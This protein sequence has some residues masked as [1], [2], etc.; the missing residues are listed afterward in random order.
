MRKKVKIKLYIE[1][2]PINSVT[3]FIGKGIYWFFVCF[4]SVA[5]YVCKHRQIYSCLL[6]SNV[7]GSILPTALHV[8][9]LFILLTICLGD[10]STLVKKIIF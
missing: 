8:V 10:L 5:E 7:R 3:T 6:L 4:S 9:C 1:A 2:S